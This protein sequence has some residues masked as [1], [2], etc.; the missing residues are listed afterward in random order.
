MRIASEGH[1]ARIILRFLQLL[2]IH[3]VNPLS[4]GGRK[5]S[6]QWPERARVAFIPDLH[7]LV[8]RQMSVSPRLPVRE[9]ITELGCSSLSG[10]KVSAPNQTGVFLLPPGSYL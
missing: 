4:L 5:V 2:C 8:S 6:F 9:Q 10:A 3:P 7:L 1:S